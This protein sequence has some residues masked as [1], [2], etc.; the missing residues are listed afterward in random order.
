[1]ES[2]KYVENKEKPE[3]DEI[4]FV[5][6]IKPIVKNLKIIIIIPVV[7]ALIFG[8]WSYF[9]KPYVYKSSADLVIVPVYQQGK[10]K[11]QF[12]VYFFK[13]ILES[14]SF[15]SS[16]TKKAREK[17]LLSGKGELK[18]GKNV[19]VRIFTARRKEAKVLSPVIRVYVL[20]ETPEKAYDIL[21][22]LVNEF[23]QEANQTVSD[24]KRNFIVSA[25]KEFPKVK[26]NYEKI[27]KEY[28]TVKNKYLITVNAKESEIKNK[29]DEFDLKSAQQL[30]EFD[31]KRQQKRLKLVH[32][33][34]QGLL[35]IKEE[36]KE[37]RSKIESE[38][39]PEITEKQF[40]EIQQEYSSKKS[41]LKVI[42]SKL[43]EKKI[44]LENLKK[45]LANTPKT[46]SLN[47]KGV[48]FK[49]SK[50]EVNPNYLKLT[51][52]IQKVSQEII[53]LEAKKK[54]ILKNLDS[55]KNQYNVL[56][57]KNNNN[58]K[59]LNQFDEETENK[60]ALYEKE[61][62]NLLTYF[63]TETD[64]LRKKLKD[65]LDLK[66]KKLKNNLDEELAKLKTDFELKLTSLENNQ[67]YLENS[68]KK[69]ADRYSKA[70]V[71]KSEIDEPVKVVNPPYIPLRPE[72]RKIVRKT[73]VVGFLLGILMII[74]VYIKEFYVAHKKE[75]LGD[76]N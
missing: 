12:N 68:F 3:Y 63:D 51:S 21:K 60:L 58:K 71:M 36:R 74:F 61:T 37:K 31:K 15:L 59:I 53:N 9:S 4:D 2:E 23:L 39:Q 76:K 73:V 8:L 75:L 33:R 49:K 55:L 28:N 11:N 27:L 19:F 52:E 30:M 5:E 46:I 70:I 14:S 25:E 20:A 40:E 6:L 22:M 69:L 7:G 42:D 1:M 26:N 50:E 13:N 18:L 56:M 64:I 47:S 44:I 43:F 67:L 72:P 41:A 16:V 10:E 38:L 34:Q 57:N 45:M 24:M 48:L 29:L 17:G 32:Q 54:N 35:K 66:R 65:D 62:E